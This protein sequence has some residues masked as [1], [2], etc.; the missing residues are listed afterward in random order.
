[1]DLIELV[2]SKCIQCFN[3]TLTFGSF[4][5]TAMQALLGLAVLSILLTFIRKLLDW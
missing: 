4:S 1:M 2:I 3:V 5:F